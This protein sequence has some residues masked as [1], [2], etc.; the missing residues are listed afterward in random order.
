MGPAGVVVSQDDGQPLCALGAV[1]PRAPVG[2]F[3]KAG[4]DEPLGLAIGLGSIGFREG[5][6]DVQGLASLG[7]QL[8][9][10]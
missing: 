7:K 8:L 2:P 6:F 1:G 3:A 4:L 10:R 5:V 9:E